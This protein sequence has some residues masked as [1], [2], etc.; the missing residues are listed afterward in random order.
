MPIIEKFEKDITI[1]KILITSSTLSSSHIFSKYKLKKT[2]HQFYP[3]DLNF[4]T[5]FFISYW[6]PKLAIF[7]DSEIWPNMYCNLSK[8][9]I[10]LILLNARLTRKSFN[11]WKYFPKFSEKIFKRI[12]VALPQ[13]LESKRYLKLLEKNIKYVGNPSFLNIAKPHKILN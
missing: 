11:R 4:L 3:F 2:I 10:P 8:R 6:K 7:V 13:N 12:T 5:S 9:G 1:K